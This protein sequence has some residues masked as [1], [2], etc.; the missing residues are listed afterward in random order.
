MVDVTQESLRTDRESARK[1]GPKRGSRPAP[2]LT[3]NR[4]RSAIMAK[5]IPSNIPDDVKARFWANVVVRG[6]DECWEWT[7]A[8]TDKG[9]AALSFRRGS[10]IALALAGKPRT[11]RCALH[12][13]DN[14]GC[15]NPNHLRWGTDAENVADMVERKRHQANRKTHCV[16]GHAFEGDNLLVRREGHRTCRKCRLIHLH[17]WRERNR[18]QAIREQSNG[19]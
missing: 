2:A 15:V 6:P 3:N 11:A 12:S 9:Y 14:P 18:A 7:G 1:V 19:A 8:K 16:R 4:I 13:C 10:H 17:A 5:P